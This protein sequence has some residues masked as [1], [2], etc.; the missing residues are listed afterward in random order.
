MNTRIGKFIR[1]AFFAALGIFFLI[2]ALG[3]PAGGYRTVFFAFFGLDIVWSVWLL[4]S[5]IRNR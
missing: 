3:M 2:Y 1:S 4:I 5:A